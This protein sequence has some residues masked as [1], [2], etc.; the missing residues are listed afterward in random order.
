[1]LEADRLHRADAAET[2][3]GVQRDRCGVRG[4]A[5]HRD[6]LAETARLG[7]VDQPRQERAGPMPR[8]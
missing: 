7:A 6:H 8:R 3:S 4:V 2:G 5:D 1:M